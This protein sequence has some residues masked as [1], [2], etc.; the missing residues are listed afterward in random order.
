MLDPKEVKKAQE[1]KL[2]L[3]KSHQEGQKKQQLPNFLSNSSTNPLSLK[4]IPSASQSMN[5]SVSQRSNYR[6]NQ[7]GGKQTTLLDVLFAS[8][9]AEAEEA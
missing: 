2:A 1:A 7:G 6:Q 5:G 8:E 4:E 3:A 9:K